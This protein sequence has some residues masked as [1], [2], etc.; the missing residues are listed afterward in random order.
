MWHGVSA[1]RLVLVI[2][3]AVGAGAAAVGLL[4]GWLVS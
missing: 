3:A 1:D 4:I 2:C